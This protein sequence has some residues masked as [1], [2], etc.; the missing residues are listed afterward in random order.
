[1]LKLE[2]AKQH[3]PAG[4]IL[5]DNN[6]KVSECRKWWQQKDVSQL[7]DEKQI[8]DP[9]F[10]TLFSDSAEKLAGQVRG[11]LCNLNYCL[12]LAPLPVFC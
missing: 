5:L 11:I 6:K 10:A 8:N 1:M 12:L 3:G 2:T 9:V 4:I 7:D